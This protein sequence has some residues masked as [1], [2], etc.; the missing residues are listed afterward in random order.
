MNDLYDNFKT[1]TSQNDL[2]GNNHKIQLT[3][4]TFLLGIMLIVLGLLL[5]L[6]EE[7]N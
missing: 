7:M 4:L 3:E 1:F 5:L 6:L 2:Y